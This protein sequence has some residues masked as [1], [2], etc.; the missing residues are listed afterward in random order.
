M[1][2]IVIAIVLITLIYLFVLY[3]E[4]KD[5]EFIKAEDGNEYRVQINDDNE[6]TAELLSKAVNKIKN[7]I[8]HLKK[9]NSD[10]IRTNTLLNRFDVENITENNKNEAKNGITSYTVNKG[11]KVVVCLRQKN[12]NLVDLNTLMY[13]IIHEMAHICDLTSKQHD[14]K[15]WNNF[16]WLLKEA[17]NIGIYTYEDYEENEK[18]Y[19]GID[20]TSNVIDDN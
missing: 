18:P 12:G 8:N 5:H 9:N 7:L 19:C 15:F 13:V 2:N 11:E 1:E 14:D 6:K 3:Y 20:I 10:D 4:N 16:E 17:I